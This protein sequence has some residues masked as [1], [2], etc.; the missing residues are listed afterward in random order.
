MYFGDTAN[1]ARPVKVDVQY[2]GDTNW[3]PDLFTPAAM[4]RFARAAEESGYAA[5]AFT[6]HP[7]PS[8]SW[9][10]G[11]GEGSIDLFTA[12]SFCAAVT[13]T[14]RLLTLVLVL[15][16][17]NPFLAAHQT[18]SLDAVSGG[19]LIVGTGTG[20]LRSEFHALGADF[21]NRRE[22]FD[23]AVEVMR[24]AW[25][26]GPVAFR[27]RRFEARAVDPRPLPVQRPGPPLWIHGNSTWGR[28]RAA[29]YGDG[30]MCFMADAKLSATTRTAPV[31]DI[32]ALVDAIDDLR[33]RAADAGRDP[34]AIEVAVSGQWPLLDV[35][36]GW[37]STRM[38]DQLAELAE[39]GVDRVMAVVCG[40]DPGAAE[41]T[42][43]RLGE[44]VVVPSAQN[45]ATVN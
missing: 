12:L 5:L 29:R 45:D 11:G 38:R 40:D 25:A 35:R 30:W 20:Y 9:A 3:T 42:V 17:R 41:D 21:D 43:R 14:I 19:R 4:T 39:V 28:A 7:A 15:P 26:G 1:G 36:R 6:D 13:S 34:K 37:D 24:A 2:A 27:G 33:C 22:A 16:Y 8:V 31:E 23:E 10:K 44:E 32:R 18:A